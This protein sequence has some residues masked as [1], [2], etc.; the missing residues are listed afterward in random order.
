MA[1][2]EL[3]TSCK[4]ASD[5]FGIDLSVDWRFKEDMEDESNIRPSRDV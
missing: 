5:M 1:L 2:E 3:K 4:K